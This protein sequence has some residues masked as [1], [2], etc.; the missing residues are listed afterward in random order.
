M[1]KRPL[2][3]AQWKVLLSDMSNLRLQA[4]KAEIWITTNVQSAGGATTA[5]GPFRW[6][7]VLDGKLT[8]NSPAGVPRASSTFAT[9]A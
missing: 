2:N 5:P 3:P 4:Y 6:S 8:K 9:T 1:S 7:A